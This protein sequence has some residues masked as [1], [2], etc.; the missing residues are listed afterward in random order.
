MLSLAKFNKASSPRQQIRTD[1]RTFTQT[2]A[3]TNTHAQTHAPT[4]THTYTPHKHTSKQKQEDSSHSHARKV[5]KK[6]IPTNTHL[7]DSSPP[8]PHKHTH[9]QTNKQT[10]GKSLV[11]ELLFLLRYHANSI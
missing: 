5:T 7:Q 2:H 11:I 8:S 3:Q 9:T 6:H 4:Q 1:G 10:E